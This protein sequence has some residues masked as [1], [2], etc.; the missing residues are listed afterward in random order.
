MCLKE[1]LGHTSNYILCVHVHLSVGRLMN[2]ARESLMEQNSSG[3][4]TMPITF[5][6]CELHLRIFRKM[7]KID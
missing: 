7:N 4:N 6:I 3:T 2:G 1:F 5:Y